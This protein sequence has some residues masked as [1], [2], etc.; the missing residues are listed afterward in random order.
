MGENIDDDD[1]TPPTA[2]E[3]KIIEARQ[4]RSNQISKLMGSYML[5]GYRML[6]KLCECGTIFLQDRDGTNYCVACNELE[7]ECA[8][9]D[10]V[11]SSEAARVAALEGQKEEPSV[12]V[13]RERMALYQEIGGGT[14]AMPQDVNSMPD[15]PQKLSLTHEQGDASCDP[16]EESQCATHK[17][18]IFELQRQITTAT[19]ELQNCSSLELRI[20]LCNLIK[21]ASEAI[22]ALNNVNKC[23]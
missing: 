4:E 3:M 8:K 13:N 9:D 20:Q 18:T 19:K 21:S 12:N 14:S 10:P 23:V 17:T 6:D 11:L 2:A 16:M 5:K 1:W 22:I 15:V 7:S